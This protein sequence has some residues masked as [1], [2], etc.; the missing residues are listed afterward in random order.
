MV[1]LGPP[2]AGKGTQ[3]AAIKKRFG[4]AHISTGDI[5]RENVKS[6]TRLGL[7]AKRY[8]DAGRLVPDDTIINMMRERLREDDAGSGFILDGYPRT[9]AQAE[10]LGVLLKEMGLCLDTVVLLEI[11]DDDVV[12]RLGGR[13]VCSNCG[14]IYH[15]AGHPAEKEGI[16]DSCGGSVIQRGDDME[17]VI[18]ERLAVYHAETSQLVEYY[19]KRRLL[20]RVDAAGPTDAVLTSIESP[21]VIM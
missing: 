3:A 4:L 13:R 14:A 16:C 12:G 18:R 15:V 7:A 21:K 20:R 8:M 10:E 19:E 11:S 5:L 9:V 17:S 2:G 6:C 1:L